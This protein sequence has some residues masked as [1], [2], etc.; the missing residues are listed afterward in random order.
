MS[1]ELGRRIAFTLGALLV[2]RLGSYIPIPGIDIEVLQ[3]LFRRQPGGLFDM[4][5]MLAGGGVHRLSIFALNIAPYFTAAIVVQLFLLF[6]PRA[7]ARGRAGH[8]GRTGVMRWT[9]GLAMAFAAF[10]AFGIASAL[11]GFRDL[12]AEPGPLF[13]LSTVVSLTGGTLFLVWLCE[14]ITLRGVGNGL[15]LLLFVG[16]VTQV[17]ASIGKT[18]E[19][20]RDG[21]LN[22]NQILGLGIFAVAVIGFIVVMERARRRVPIEFSGRQV[23]DRAIAAQASGL[24]LKLNSAGV[25]PVVVAPWLLYIAIVV[26]DLAGGFDTAWVDSVTRN[27]GPGS[28]GF[29]IVT[30]IAIVLFAFIYTAFVLDPEAAAEKLKAYGGVIPGIAPGEATAAHMDY[31]V[32]RTTVLGASYLALIVLIPELVI[33]YAKVPFYFGG[34]SAL[35]AVCVVLDISAQVGAQVGT[36]VATQVRGDGLAKTGG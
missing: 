1:S 9:L 26:A 18:L 36:Q 6:F 14:L 21:I 17:P 33:A 34:V 31:V 16:I 2:F 11:E 32:S 28:P 4:A 12:V 3:Q 8:R 35:I 13:R 29:M 23:G 10:Q 7:G 27:F 22:S 5:D 19:L 25:I 30:V 20:G 24:P 15:G